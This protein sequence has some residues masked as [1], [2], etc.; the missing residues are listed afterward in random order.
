M[1]TI[2]IS[3][4]RFLLMINYSLRKKKIDKQNL[5]ISK[6][7]VGNFIVIHRSLTLLQKIEAKNGYD[8]LEFRIKKIFISSSNLVRQSKGSFYR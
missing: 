3:F 1:Y 5:L 6:T 8:Y 2:N 7:K 4:I